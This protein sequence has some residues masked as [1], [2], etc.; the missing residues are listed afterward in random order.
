MLSGFDGV[1]LAQ[2]AYGAGQI[3][4]A[5]REGNELRVGSLR[6]LQVAGVFGFAQRMAGNAD[7]LAAIGFH[8]LTDHRLDQL[9]AG[10]VL[11]DDEPRLHALP[12]L[13]QSGGM[14]DGIDIPGPADA[15]AVAIFAGQPVGDRCA[16]EH[17]PSLFSGQRVDRQG[18]GGSWNVEDRIHALLVKPVPR[19]GDTEFGIVLVVG[20]HQ[21]GSASHTGIFD[22]QAGGIYRAL[23]GVNR[24]YRAD[25]CQHADFHSRLRCCCWN[26]QQKA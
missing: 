26:G 12:H 2:L 16:E 14:S 10:I 6:F 17:Q 25:I 24:K 1:G 19:D 18:D 7:Y 5:G 21:V 15:V 20:K 3:R 22:R 8:G 9:S 4:P 11:G 13:R 23:A